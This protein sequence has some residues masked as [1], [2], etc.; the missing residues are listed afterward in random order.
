[1]LRKAVYLFVFAGFADWEAAHAVAEL[2]R[3]GGYRVEVVG[4][5]SDP[6]ESMGG[7]LVQPSSKLSDVDLDDIAML[8]LPG[9]DYWEQQSTHPELMRV[10]HAVDLR[11]I[12][13][14]AICAATTL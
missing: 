14:A 1:M 6:V 8:I 7:I 5:N 9:G 3:H 4:I 2:R 13:I 10:L 11:R 12:P